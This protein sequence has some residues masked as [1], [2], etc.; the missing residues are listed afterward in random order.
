MN[1]L[2][3]SLRGS[4]ELLVRA[5]IALNYGSLFTFFLGLFCFLLI[6][7]I[8]YVVLCILIVLPICCIVIPVLLTNPYVVS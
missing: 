4:K 6:S 7:V 2:S 1:F 3:L 5:G 8:I